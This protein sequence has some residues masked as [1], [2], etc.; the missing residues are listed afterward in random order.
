MSAWLYVSNGTVVR[1]TASSQEARA[2]LKPLMESGQFARLERLKRLMRAKQTGFVP[3]RTL[4]S[5]VEE[6]RNDPAYRE[7]LYPRGMGWGTGL[8]LSL[9]TGDDMAMSL[10]RAYDKGSAS[11]AEVETLNQVHPH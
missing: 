8:A 5:S 9:P 1:W 3:D 11:P 2:D 6:M 10:E 4:Y 7:I